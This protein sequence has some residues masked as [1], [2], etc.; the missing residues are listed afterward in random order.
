MTPRAFGSP[1][2]LKAE[3]IHFFFFD[4]KSLPPYRPIDVFPGTVNYFEK[5]HMPACN[6][7]K[8]FRANPETVSTNK[9]EDCT[10]GFQKLSANPKA[11]KNL[12]V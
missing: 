4:F 8:G 11:A 12:L 3:G 10:L 5:R 1:K 6:F 7:S 2:A 9:K